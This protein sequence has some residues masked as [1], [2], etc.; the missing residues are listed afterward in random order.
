MSSNW[1][2]VSIEAELVSLPDIYWRLRD[3]L[4]GRDYALQEVSDLIACDP[5]LSARL[6]RLV[7]SAG[8]G[9]PSSIETVAH[10]ISMVGVG[11]V[12]EL[13]LTTAVADTLGD[14]SCEQLDVRRFWLRSVNRAICARLLAADCHVIN[15]Q[16]LFVTGLLSCVGLLI[17]YRSMPVLARQARDMAADSGLPLHLAEREIVGFDHAAIGAL[18]LHNWKLPAIQVAAIER[19]YEPDPAAE[20]FLETAITHVAVV[21]GNAI[22]EG[23]ALEEAV[24]AIDPRAWEVAGLD[25]AHCPA[26]E[27]AV[28]EQFT[29]IVGLLFPKMQLAAC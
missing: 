12:E 9:L 8:F 22:T 3:I 21:L 25:T 6:L 10:A 17:L 4:D 23:R 5:G 27:D 29:E 28:A 14:Y 20:H 13:V 7:N 15:H 16:R 26:I 24:A 1:D 19:Q 11:Q 2:K 18:L